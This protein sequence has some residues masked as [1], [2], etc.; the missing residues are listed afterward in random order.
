MNRTT[1]YKI[2]LPI[3]ILVM[4]CITVLIYLNSGQNHY[5]LLILV[6]VFVIPGRVCGVFWR[7]FFKGRNLMTQKRYNEA[8]PYFESFL[9]K[10]KEKPWIKNLM[11]FSW[12]IYTRDIEAMTLNNLGGIYIEQSEILKAEEYFKQAISIDNLYPL[13]YYGLAIIADI[14][15]NRDKAITLLKESEGKGLSNNSL[16]QAFRKSGEILAKI[17]GRVK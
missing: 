8:I 10:V 9:I 1:Q 14:K 5:L 7:D 15:G 13:P 2:M 11:I 16:D 6:I 4:V 3:V 17:E 12:G